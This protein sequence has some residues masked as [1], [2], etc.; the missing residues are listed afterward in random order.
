[1]VLLLLA[2]T[3]ETGRTWS[4]E[5]EAT[6]HKETVPV[7]EPI[8]RRE[9]SILNAAADNGSSVYISGLYI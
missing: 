7:V 3:V 5:M 1:M 9:P 6:S 8:A 2:R 4:R